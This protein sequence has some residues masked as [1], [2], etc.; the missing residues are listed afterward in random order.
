MNQSRQPP[1]SGTFS[2]LLALLLVIGWVAPQVAAEESG[3]VWVNT[4]SGVYHCPGTQYY[5]NTKRGKYLDEAQATASGYRAAYGR[6]CSPTAARSGQSQ[7]KQTVAA[8]PTGADTQVWVNTGSGIYHC[9]GTRYYGATKRGRY[10]SE[11]D[12]AASGNRPAH[13]ARCGR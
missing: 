11:A 10:M 2:L 9:P 6:P 4:S 5:G 13:G 7:A 8:Q 1:R 12:A 3:K